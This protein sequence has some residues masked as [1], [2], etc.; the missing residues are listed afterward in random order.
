MRDVQPRKLRAYRT[1]DG[2]EPFTE[3]LIS[4]HDRNTRNRIERRLD[5]IRSGNF[6]D[7]RSVGAAV[8]AQE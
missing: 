3:W 8:E 5:R 2:R 7:Y 1:S 6:G 4:V